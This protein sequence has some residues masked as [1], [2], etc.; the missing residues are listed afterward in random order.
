MLAAVQQYLKDPLLD[1]LQNPLLDPLEAVIQPP[2]LMDTADHPYAF[3]WAG[4]ALEKRQTAPR[5]IRQAGGGIR[6]G[7]YQL[8]TWE[9][10]VRLFTV[11][12]QEDPNI[13]L[14]FPALIDAVLLQLNTTEIPIITTDPV[15]GQQSQILTIAENV[16]MEYATARV[17]VA[18]QG[19]VRFACDLIVDVEEKV[20][21]SEGIAS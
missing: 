15:T 11:M 19:V 21:W 9:I 7:G 10:A 14:A 1:G 5:A 12:S 2:V 4:R 18:G 6:P 3:I 16:T 13:E 8:M 17:T 20:A